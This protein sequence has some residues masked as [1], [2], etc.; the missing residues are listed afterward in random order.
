MPAA[1]TIAYKGQ[2]L[3]VPDR[4][5]NSALMRFEESGGSFPAFATSPATQAV[6]LAA[7]V[8]NL[9]GDPLSHADD[10]PALPEL[11]AALTPLLESF[12][13]KKAPA[14]GASPSPAPGTPGA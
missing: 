3:P 8:F 4:L 10:L 13:E 12:G 1:I 9:P 6:K 11:L 7:A 14:P 2:L 5:K